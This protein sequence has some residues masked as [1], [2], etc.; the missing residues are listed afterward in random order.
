VLESGFLRPVAVVTPGAEARPIPTVEGDRPAA[1]KEAPDYPLAKLLAGSHLPALDGMRM[2]AVVTVIL[3]HVGYPVPADLGVNV[4]FV[5]SGFLITWLL[6]KEQARTG[7][8]SLKKFYLRRAFRLLPAYYVFLA[9]SLANYYGR[10]HGAVPQRTDI[11]L[12]SLLY[13]ANYF[14]AFH[15]HPPTPISHTWSLAV[16]EQFYV[17]WPLA[18][19]FLVGRGRPALIRFLSI[20]IVLVAAWRSFLYCVVHVGTAYVYNAFDTRFDNL[21]IGCLAAVLTQRPQVLAVAQ[22]I[23]RRSVYPA[24]VIV[25]IL[26]SRSMPSTYHYSVGFTVEALLIAVAIL[27]IMQLAARPAWRWLDYRAVRYVGTISYPMYLYHGLCNS[28]ATRVVPDPSRLYL[29]FSLALV[30]A[31]A[32]GTVS[33]YLVEKPFLRLRQ[34]LA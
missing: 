31:I 15:G 19:G 9:L 3:S 14:N 18:F 6:L 30:L 21:A 8:V 17:L 1:T 2:I 24:L 27:Q 22:T 7:A 33:F 26:A 13:Y 16:E 23:S 12:P 32:F 4:F 25:L 10:S 20:S 5:L 29:R 28:F 34:R 11:I